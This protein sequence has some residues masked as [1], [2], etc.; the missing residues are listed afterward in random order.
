MLKIT[1]YPDRYSAEAGETLDFMVTLEEGETFDARLVRVVHGDCNPEGPGLK[2]THIPSNA[3][4]SHAGKPQR[5]DAGSYAVVDRAPVLD[6]PF[7]FFTMLWPTLVRRDDQTIFAQW[8]HETDTGYH[9]GLGEGGFVSVTVGT[10]TGPKTVRAPKPMV[11]RQWYGLAVSIDP[12]TGAVGI[13]QKPVRPYAHV[14]DR[15]T[16]TLQAAPVSPAHVP[17]HFAGCP[18]GQGRYDRHFDGKIDSPI[19]MA[20]RWTA[21]DQDAV[22]RKVL[23]P[24]WRNRLIAKWDFSIGIDTADITDTGPYMLHGRLGNL[25][26]RAMKG[27]NWTGEEHSW[28]L[29]PEHY[30]AIHFHHDDVYDAGWDVSVSV[31]LPED[32]K[33]GPY[34]LHVRSGESDVDATRE[35][36]ISFFV[37]PPR[38]KARRGKRPKVAFLAPTCSYIAYA[39]HAEHITARGVEILMNRMVHFGHSDLYMYEHPELGGSLY[40]THADGSGV[41][42][43]SRLRPVLNFT[44]QYH[45]WL[46]GHGSAVYQ[47]NADTHLFDWLEEKGIDYD[48]ITDEDLNAHGYELI[49]DYEV[50]LTGTHPEYH[51]TVMWDAMKDWIDRGGRL[52][53]MGGNGWYWRVAF[54]DAWPGAMELRRAEDGIR[55]WVSE[56]GEYFHSFSGEYGGL[57]RRIGRAPNVIAGVGFI[58]QG[59]DMS[60]YYRRAPDAD[61]PRAAFIFEGVD[62][63]IIGD[64]GLVGGGAAGIELDCITTDLGSP[65]NML[66]LASSEDHSAMMLLVNEEFGPVPPNLGGDQNERVRAD[67]AFGETPAGG[68]L[69]ATSS[70]AWCGAL[71]HNGYDNNVSRITENVLRRF[72][73]PEPFDTGLS[74]NT[75]NSQ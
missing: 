18:V 50:I 35:D 6:E 16:A 11:E 57:W 21:A 68:A 23:A 47:Y 3:D 65:P 71:S 64:F 28:K 38:D 17:F 46:G 26:T 60:S 27:W 74:A 13:D 45:S 53:Y 56:P 1:G 14:D 61:N 10:E 8:D 20:G 59:F 54:N 43:S 29:K 25:P 48:V 15:C 44:A 31:T 63:E 52:M 5:I 51:S 19:L 22:M 40:D 41:A 2:F 70:I 24:E 49:E 37:V 72:M 58:A 34:A 55:P 32:I 62:D 7:T 30:G 67:L 75:G 69:F 4:G 39:N 36:Y 42:Y 9:I 66:R 33:S 12:A 73:D